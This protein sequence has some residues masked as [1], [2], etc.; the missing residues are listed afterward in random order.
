[1]MTRAR[2]L[3][4]VLARR[5]ELGLHLTQLADASET[6]PSLISNV[7][8]GFVPRLVT[9]EKIAAA[10]LTTPEALWPGEFDEIDGTPA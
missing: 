8:G 10:L 9:M 4:R 2:D 3:N 5:K 1:M 6:H 7:E